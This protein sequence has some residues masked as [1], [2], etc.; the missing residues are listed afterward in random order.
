[1]KK[2]YL[3]KSDFTN[4]FANINIYSAWNGFSSRGYE[5]IPFFY[6]DIDTLNITKDDIVCGWICSVDKA[7]SLI[8]CKVPEQPS[9][10][11]EISDY[12]G[13]KI[14]KSNLGEIRKNIPK[15]FIK[16]L[17]GHKTFNGHVLTGEFKDLIYTAEF[18]DETE[19]LVSEPV[20]FISEY[21]GFVLNNELIGFKHYTGDFKM[22]YLDIVKDAI[23]RY[24]SAPVAYSI[25]FGL[26]ENWR[27]LLIEVNDSYSL[28][29]Y[30]LDS[31]LYSKMIEA[32]WE[33]ITK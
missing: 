15:V 9:I 14:W 18:P 22:P 32:R 25:D 11:E 7:L 29:C 23:R 20:K 30:G 6:K 31:V 8:G 24:K 10:P 21:R 27:S 19:I 1:M 33:E 17:Y 26:T 16:P 2:V 28:G 3:E 13:R 4:E 5:C 12:A